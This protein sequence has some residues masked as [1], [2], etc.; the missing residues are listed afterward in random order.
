MPSWHIATL[1]EVSCH[2]GVLALQMSDDTFTGHATEGSDSHARHA[3]VLLLLLIKP[4]T[5]EVPH[6]SIEVSEGSSLEA[7]IGVA[8]VGGR[9][10]DSESAA[11]TLCTVPQIRTP[12]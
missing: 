8:A 1:R 4:L 5:G 7:K 3:P 2:L 9:S 12:T 11:W 6:W 10:T